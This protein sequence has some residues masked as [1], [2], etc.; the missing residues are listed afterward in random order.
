LAV[1]GYLKWGTT[2]EAAFSTLSLLVFLAIALVDLDTYIIPDSLCV[3]V[4]VLGVSSAMVTGQMGILLGR[5]SAGIL[6]AAAIVIVILASRGGMGFGDAKLVA[7]MGVAL[8]LQGMGV[9]LFVGF[10]M[11]AF[12]AL[13]L[14][15]TRRRSRGDAIPFGP[16]LSVGAIVSLLQGDELCR[17]YVHWS[18]L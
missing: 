12:S 18:G 3:A 13:V 11:G 16:F 9:A 10:V 8:G 4:A 7:A 5:L 6:G 2:P 15:I 14:L 17:L 1:G